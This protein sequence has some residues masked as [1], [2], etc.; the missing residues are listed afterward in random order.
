[1]DDPRKWM[2]VYSGIR[3]KIESGDI[4]IGSVLSANQ[5]ATDNGM[6]RQTAAQALRKLMDE[7]MLARYPGRGYQVESASPNTV[8]TD[9][10]Q[11]L[12]TSW[13]Q[14]AGLKPRNPATDREMAMMMYSN[15]TKALIV[16]LIELSPVLEES[17]LMLADLAF[18][19]G[20]TAADL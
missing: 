11:V 3:A 20:Q 2:Q 9:P 7:G 8:T 17:V 16:K 18:N 13:A 6:A 5:I 19:D 10:L 4:P 1:M 14:A 12:I 15:E